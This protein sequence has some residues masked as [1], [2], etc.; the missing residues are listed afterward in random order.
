MK[1]NIVALVFL[2]VAA[3]FVFSS[4]DSEAA[5]SANRGSYLAGQGIIVPADE[6]HVNSYIA[7]VDYNYPMPRGEVGIFLYSGNR[8]L[9]TSGQEE[10]IQ[11]GIQA[12]ELE[13]DEL[14]PMNLAFVID[15]SG[16]MNS[17][18]KMDWVKD[19]FRIFIAQVR[20][21][22]F[23][24]L[25]VFDSAARVIYPSTRMDSAG[26]RADFKS[27]VLGIIPDGGTNLS[28]GLELGYQQVLSNFRDDYTNRVLFLTDGMGES[29]GILQMAEQYK[30]IGINV[31]T[32]GVGTG[33][34]LDLMVA[35]A[36]SGGGSSRFISDREEMEEIFGSELDRMVV[37]ALRNL[38]MNLELPPGYRV[39][40]TWGYNNQ[41][42][43]NSARYTLP[44]LHHRDYETILVRIATPA[45]QR[46]GTSVIGRFSL[47]YESLSGSAHTVGPLEIK[48]E[49]TPE[50]TPVSGF[51]DAMV[52]RS[53]T[54]LHFA[55]KMRLIGELY[56]SC[57]G[58]IDSVNTQRE[59]IWNET[60]EAER[61]VYENITSPEISSLEDS[62]RMSMGKALDLTV[63]MKN[64]LE[65][66]RLRLDDMGFDDEISILDKYINI[67]GKE[68]RLE[69][70]AVADYSASKGVDAV[71]G[72]RSLD[73]HVAL[74]FREMSLSMS[75][76]EPGVIA[77]SGFTEKDG[78]GC[79]ML[80]FLNELAVLEMSKYDSLKVVE[81]SRLD[82]VIS[83]QKLSL[84][85]L[86]DTDTAIQVG[87][88]LSA[89]YILTGSLIE[90]PAS[91][92]V[93]G[94]IINTGSGEIE[95]VA[96]I[97]LPKNQEVSAML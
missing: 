44:T 81:R 59:K 34:D 18:N 91:V 63:S 67:L 53:G 50:S 64:E 24:S 8:Q 52:L 21:Q 95:S 89:K 61:V 11:I 22:D 51:S 13:F 12:G 69:E 55:E 9:S 82:S 93:F 15:K 30:H 36:K 6:V 48:R 43:D 49:F 75:G 58:S 68:M 60:P 77:V 85:S 83:E 94:R 57:K 35:L 86:T 62:M 37:P 41:I 70:N 46:A 19:A 25:V 7:S 71:S 88:L 4:G 1:T 90:M 27:E 14:P 96:Q 29:R 66:A 31:S 10:L 79:P 16:S 80:D 73:S 39:L 65:N 5:G 32:I 42:D 54:M 78:G 76:K 23:V 84:S 45:G 3:G 33:F 38:Q 74:L 47:S 17:A 97:V 56:Y 2:T 28:A 26:K 72:G 40:E 87:N 20:D 92:V